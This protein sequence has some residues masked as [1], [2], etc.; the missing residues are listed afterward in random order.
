MERLEVYAVSREQ[1]HAIVFDSDDLGNYHI[2][3]DSGPL[4][5]TTLSIRIAGEDGVSAI[6]FEIRE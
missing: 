6:S 5:R 1:A 4:E 2:V 3:G